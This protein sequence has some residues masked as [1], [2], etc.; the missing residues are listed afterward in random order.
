MLS[1]QDSLAH[2]SQTVG[3]VWL[4]GFHGGYV[5]FGQFLQFVVG[6]GTAPHNRGRRLQ[7]V[8]RLVWW[9]VTG[10]LCEPKRVHPRYS[11]TKEWDRIVAIELLAATQAYE[12]RR[13]ALAAPTA[14]VRAP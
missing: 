9:K 12:L 14:R 5:L 13:D 1:N 7:L 2:S 8:S 4:R 10:Q 6:K 11:D 3:P